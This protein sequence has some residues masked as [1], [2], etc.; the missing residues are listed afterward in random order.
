M[1]NVSQHPTYNRDL[2]GESFLRVQLKRAE[3]GTFRTGSE[4]D[5]SAASRGKIACPE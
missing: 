5:E 4:L 1:T 2:D 3:E